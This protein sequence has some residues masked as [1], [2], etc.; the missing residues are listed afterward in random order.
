MKRKLMW[1]AL[2]AF[3]VCFVGCYLA[4]QT[5]PL[6]ASAIEIHQAS[7]FRSIDDSQLNIDGSVKNSFYTY[8]GKHMTII[9]NKLY[10]QV[11][12]K[13]GMNN[14]PR[15]EIVEDK[16]DW[17]SISE[18]Y[19]YKEDMKEGTLIWPTNNL[20]GDPEYYQNL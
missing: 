17:A 11:E 1:G 20:C 9:D 6:S 12:G 7:I 5:K 10:I 3:S 2:V 13:I 4:L 19:I 15:F 8:E 16:G 14:N 18:I